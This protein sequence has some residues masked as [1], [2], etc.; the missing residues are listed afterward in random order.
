MLPVIVNC[1][2]HPSSGQ[3]DACDLG[4]AIDTGSDRS[5]PDPLQNC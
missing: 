2:C 4:V 3:S 1:T 5:Q